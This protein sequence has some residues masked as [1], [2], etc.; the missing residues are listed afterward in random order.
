[1]EGEGTL[2]DR[3]LRAAERSP[4]RG[5]V[6]V[7]ADGTTRPTS[8][9]EVLGQALRIAGGLQARGLRPGDRVLLQL[10]A[11]DELFAAFLGCVTAGTVPMTL[12][13]P[14]AYAL[15]S[16]AHAKL[17]AAW[18]MLGQPHVLAGTALADGVRGLALPDGAR[19]ICH[20]L[21]EL[22]SSPPI[23]A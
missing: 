6:H 20:A 2:P 15:P 23:P 12:L 21:D 1:G 18:G 13:V 17:T 10:D 7:L 19:W 11:S 16:P 14:R 22:L 5:Y 4:T 9:R 8:Y 3:L